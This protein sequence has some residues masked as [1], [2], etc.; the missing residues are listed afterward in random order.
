MPATHIRWG[1][2]SRDLLRGVMPRPNTRG[3][4]VICMGGESVVNVIYAV[5][6]KAS[7]TFPAASIW[8]RALQGGTI[9]TS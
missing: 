8:V 9:T 7:D 1:V 3:C 2:T 5:F 4:L 6:S